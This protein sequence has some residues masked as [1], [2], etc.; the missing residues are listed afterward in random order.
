MS[1]KGL[2]V[3]KGRRKGTLLY[4]LRWTS[5][6]PLASRVPMYSRLI[7]ALVKDPRVPASRKA[8]IIAAVGYVVLGRKPFADEIPVLG[9]IDDVIVLVLAVEFFFDGI[10]EYILQEKIEELG[11]DREA[12]ERDLDQVRRVT[13]APV[14]RIVSRLPD[15]L[16]AASR[17]VE[18]SGIGPKVK[19][20]VT[21]VRPSRA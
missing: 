4:A 9:Q 3:S 12:F 6:L 7:W 20:W 13:P 18:E 2:M 21:D 8:I 17:L 5:F 10:P 16:E 19:T 1:I 14:R 15:V 11:I